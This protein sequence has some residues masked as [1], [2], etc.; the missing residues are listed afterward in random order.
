MFLCGILLLILL[1]MGKEYYSSR[2]FQRKRLEQIYAAYGEMPVRNYGPEELAHISM[3]YKKHP[4]ADQ[5]DDIT[6]NDLHMDAVYQRLNTCLCAAGD[7]YLYYRLRTPAENV[8]ELLKMERRICFFM[9]HEEERHSLQKVFYMLGRTGRHSLYEYLDQLDLLGDRRNTKYFFFDLLLLLC[10]GGMFLSMPAGL[11]CLLA[12]LSHNIITYFKEYREV[13]PYVTSFAYVRRLLQ[14]AE[15]L[16]GEKIGEISEEL[17]AI[18]FSYSRLKGFLRSSYLTASASQGNGNPMEV[19]FD[20]LRMFLYLDLIRFNSALRALRAHM[21]EVDQ[22]VTIL[23]QLECVVA[24]GAYRKSLGEAY[25]SPVLQEN[26]GEPLFVETEALYHPLLREP[27]AN[28]LHTCKGVLITGSNAS[29]KSTFLRTVAVNAILAQTIHTC[30]A[31]VYRASFFRV[32]S[33]MSLKD[34]LAGGDS[35][36]MVEIKSIKRILDQVQQTGKRPVLCFVDEV[37]RGT[38]TVERIAASTQIMR[39]LAEGPVL[40]FAA[41]HDVELTKLLS[42]EYDNYHFE[43]RMEEKDI[44]FPYK[45]MK[46]PATTRNAIALLKLLGYD[47]RITA[48]A[49]HMA[50]RFLRDG[51]WQMEVDVRG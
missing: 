42:Q 28:S 35:Y 25:C 3:Y 34:D 13:E 37:L 17:A 46:G 40:C 18:R 4:R 51:N 22:M 1:L 49:E 14:G 2:Q 31:T 44:F 23:G 38:N 21:G 41:T 27:V 47:E 9:E 32:C 50:E 15:A 19:L 6:W 12:V 45:L 24:V 7:E 33:S 20:Y 8:D 29:G 39:M 10:V 16:G 26:K 36:Y 30:A 48:S 43:E 11:V 5:I